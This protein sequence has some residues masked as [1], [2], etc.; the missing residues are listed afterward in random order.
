ME[1]ILG[2]LLVLLV[3]FVVSKVFKI[4]GKAVFAIICIGVACVIV[5]SLGVI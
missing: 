3:A 1:S 5:K 4:A 2:I